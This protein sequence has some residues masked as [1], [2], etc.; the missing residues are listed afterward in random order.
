[1]RSERIAS[2]SITIDREIQKVHV[3]LSS[4]FMPRVCT[5]PKTKALHQQQIQKTSVAKM[6]AKVAVFKEQNYGTSPSTTQ[7]FAQCL[8]AQQNTGK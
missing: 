7:V 8:C 2:H 4:Y 1:M 6:P 5:A 3:L